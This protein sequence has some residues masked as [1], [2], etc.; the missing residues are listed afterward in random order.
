M[1]RTGSSRSAAPAVRAIRTP[2]GIAQRM[3]LASGRS[4]SLS[5]PG[6]PSSW[7]RFRMPAAPRAA[8]AGR[9]DR[10]PWARAKGARLE[11]GQRGFVLTHQSQ[12]LTPWEQARE[13]LPQQE[14]AL[15]EL[16]R[17]DSAQEA[18]VREIAGAVR[19]SIDDYSVALVDAAAR[20]DPSA[21]TVAATAEGNARIGV[22]RDD[23]TQLL[24]AERRTSA[25]TGPGP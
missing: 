5:A 11:T 23:F 4:R 2:G 21:H 24:E 19:S 1:R 15:L 12:L 3:L 22:I 8:F 7:S 17:G 25:G 20:G 14:R 6:S 18:R 16:V 9:A 13:E 10:R